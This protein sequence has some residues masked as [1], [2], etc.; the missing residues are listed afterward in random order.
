MAELT[1][2]ERALKYLRMEQ[3]DKIPIWHQSADLS[4]KLV[5]CSW[6]E[7]VKDPRKIA[8]GHIEYVR[9]FKPDM[10]GIG[11]H[12]W[13]SVEALGLKFQVLDWIVQPAPYPARK[14]PNPEIY[15]QIEYRDPWSTESAKIMKE[16]CHIYTEAVGG[17]ILCRQGWYGPSGML[18]MLVG[19]PEVMR[20]ILIFPEVVFK[21]LR[22]VMVDYAADFITGLVEAMEPNIT[23]ICWAMSQYDWD[24]CPKEWWDVMAE[25]D[26]ACFTKVKQNIKKKTGK[27]VPITT[28]ICAP[29]PALDYI[30]EKFGHLIKE[31]QYW[32][33]MCPYSLEQAV[34]NFGDKIPIMTGIDHTRTLLMGTPEEVDKM[35]KDAIDTAKGKCSFALGPGCD[36]AADTPEANLLALVEARD[37]YGTYV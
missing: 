12:M 25:T 28:H 3:P 36:I 30:V 31:I 34:E 9:R 32:G 26:I 23:N 5:G 16:A 2:L 10:S 15:K 24:M 33:P 29:N 21:T 17:E 19:V 37:K 14:R 22:E 11:T 27:D 8:Q 18:G 20:D 13:W 4:R 35:V 1:G 7:F 6:P